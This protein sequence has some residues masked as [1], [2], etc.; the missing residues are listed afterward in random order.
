M[1]AGEPQLAR[2]GRRRQGCPHPRGRRQDDDGDRLLSA[3]HDDDPAA[4][5]RRCPLALGHREPTTLVLGRHHEPP[6]PAFGYGAAHPSAGGTST[7][8]ICTLPSA[9]CGP[10]LFVTARSARSASCS[11][12][13]SYPPRSAAPAPSSGPTR[14][15]NA[16]KPPTTP[17]RCELASCTLD[18]ATPQLVPHLSSTPHFWKLLI[19]KANPGN[20]ARRGTTPRA[21][22]A[23][24]RRG[25][26]RRRRRD[27]RRQLAH[28]RRQG[29]A[30]R[31]EHAAGAT[32]CLRS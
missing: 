23:G 4:A 16:G 12:S 17:A 19:G 7:L 8:L 14:H 1:A 2:P 6:D 22:A 20:S 13:A 27:G 10:N 29:D 21:T 25:W 31:L 30:N 5:P 11:A 9:Q 15:D 26:R 24:R 28:Q 32:W 3:E 18:W